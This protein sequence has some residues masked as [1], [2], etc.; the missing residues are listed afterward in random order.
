ML[1]PVANLGPIVG[2]SLP[3]ETMAT[4]CLGPKLVI[5]NTPEKVCLLLVIIV[6]E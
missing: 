2:L 6:F 3:Y 5:S 4:F 1:F